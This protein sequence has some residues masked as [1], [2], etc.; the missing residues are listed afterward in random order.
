MRQPADQVEALRL[1]VLAKLEEMKA[2]DPVVADVRGRSSLYDYAMLVSGTSNR[3]LYAMADAVVQ[4]G[5]RIGS[6]PL[7]VSGE[8]DAEWILVDF[9]DIVLHLMLRRTREHYQLEKLWEV[10]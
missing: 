10:G 4:A 7:S 2:L 6:P 3:H 5:K 8:R 9:G 1:A